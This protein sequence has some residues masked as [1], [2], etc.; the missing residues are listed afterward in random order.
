M[1]PWPDILGLIS[2]DLSWGKF[3]PEIIAKKFAMR[4][5]LAL[6]EILE[7][8]EALFS[9]G[10]VMSWRSERLNMLGDM[11]RDISLP[12]ER[13]RINLNVGPERSAIQRD[14]APMTA[15]VSQEEPIG[16]V[17][18]A[19]MGEASENVKEQFVRLAI[20]GR[21][22]VEMKKDA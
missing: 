3:S 2:R 8:C 6:M 12:F 13:P 21:Q 22:V 17:L 1:E 9:K 10:T 20:D 19:F 16:P 15:N 18:S 7:T 14:S 11:C 4:A 5:V